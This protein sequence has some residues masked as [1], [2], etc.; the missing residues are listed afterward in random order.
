METPAEKPARDVEKNY[1]KAEFI[2]KIRRLA[3]S[4]ES[5]SR[6]VISVAGERVYVPA[7]AE[8]SIEHERSGST[9]EIE[10]QLRWTVPSA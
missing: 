6:F 1:P 5:G 9:E 3:D 2:E 4:L 7:G 8:I 10:F